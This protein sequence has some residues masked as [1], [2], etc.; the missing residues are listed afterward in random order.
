MNRWVKQQVIA[1]LLRAGRPRLAN[2]VA[3]VVAKLMSVQEALNWLNM[4]AEKLGDAATLKKMY[5]DASMK[6][7]PDR[8]GTKEAMQKVNEAYEVLRKR[9][10]G[11]GFTSPSDRAEKDL[12]VEQ[13]ATIMEQALRQGFNE[14]AFTQHIEKATG[15]RFKATSNIERKKTHYGY[16]VDL[17]AEWKSEDGLTTFELRAWANAERFSW[18]PRQLGG[19][20]QDYSFSVSAY[21]RIFHETRK[22][23]F[24]Q[25]DWGLSSDSRVVLN[26]ESMFPASKIK[27]MKGGKEKKR[28]FSKRDM[29]LGLEKLVGA[30]V[31]RSGKDDIA[32]VPLGKDDAFTLQMR[33]MTMMGHAMW[34][35][36][37]TLWQGKIGLRSSVKHPLGSVKDIPEADDV[38]KALAEMRRKS[39]T[40]DDPKQIGKLIEQTTGQIYTKWVGGQS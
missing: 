37:R 8:G 33:R 34:I 13:A 3:M 6:H 11:S 1:E 35:V 32:D 18:G 15:K 25:S 17:F 10:G 16:N 30:K 20:G 39:A 2:A 28:K 36:S 22:V 23:K 5:R 9:D 24:R 26:P 14:K 31:W 27:A 40:M 19:G 4:D 29:L 38:L 12:K 7:H 21:S